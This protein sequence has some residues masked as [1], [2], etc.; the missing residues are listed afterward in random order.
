MRS[1]LLQISHWPNPSH[2][3]VPGWSESKSLA[4]WV[5][6]RLVLK[7]ETRSSVEN[8]PESAARPRA[9]STAAVP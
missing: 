7:I 5:S 9:S 8:L 1:V 2:E 6:P 4:L 3:E